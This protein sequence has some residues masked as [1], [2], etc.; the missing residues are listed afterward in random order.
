M[1]GRFFVRRCS[2][3]A[4]GPVSGLVSRAFGSQRC[5]GAEGEGGPEL[6]QGGGVVGPAGRQGRPGPARPGP[7]RPGAC[8]AVPAP[9]EPVRPAPAL[10]RAGRD[11]WS[12]W[13][14]EVGVQ[15]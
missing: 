5:L 10:L 3:G 11:S 6:P 7:A 9:A 15:T 8:A 13:G 4:L 1:R 12:G 14:S 2:C